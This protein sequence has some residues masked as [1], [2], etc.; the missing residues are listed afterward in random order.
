MEIFSYEKLSTQTKKYLNAISNSTKT[1]VFIFVLLL[2]GA[3]ISSRWFDTHSFLSR[4]GNSR[5]K[6]PWNTTQPNQKP[7]S[8]PNLKSNP[9]SSPFT[10]ICP[11]KNPS[12]TCS[13]RPSP[14]LNTSL[15]PASPP[16]PLASLKQTCPDY[17]RWIHE[18]LRPWASTGITREMLGRAA[19]HAAFRLIIVDGHP[20]IHIYHHVY[21]T[22]DIFTIWGILQLLRRYPGRVPDLDLMF[23]C[24]D[25][26]VVHA[27]N[28][29]SPP[30]LFRYCKD[31][32]TL[33]IVFPDWSFWGWPE[34]NIMPWERQAD[35]LREANER[36]PWRKR[37]P[38]AY[39]KGNPDVARTRG[40][41]MKCNV[42]TM[43]DWEAR[44]FRVNWAKEG[45]QKFKGANLAKQCTYRYKIYIEG[46]AW[47][48][49]EKYI[50][51]CD[52]PTLYVQS[53]FQDFVSRGLRP[54]LHYWPIPQDDK[55]RAIKQAVEWGNAH[56]LEMEAIG[57]EGS[58]FIHDQLHMNIVYDYMLHLLTEYSKLLTF[59][60]TK[61]EEAM[62]LCLESVACPFQGKIRDSLME[63][64]SMEATND[65]EPCSLPSAFGP[66]E[67]KE[68]LME[69]TSDG[70]KKVVESIIMKSNGGDRSDANYE[71]IK[72]F[73]LFGLYLVFNFFV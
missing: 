13:S 20:Y 35:E 16:T 9:N 68:L 39:W 45:R 4:M 62:D 64:M 52:S 37:E 6:F 63:S 3:F 70:T 73:L 18:D 50:I 26:P 51:G 60:P 58:S 29:Q 21:Q 12:N 27:I 59:K 11:T 30:P 42:T 32:T 14:F 19:P 10:L 47:S 44:L 49:S 46:N 15:S 53:R 2:M 54:G 38:Y 55:C 43:N 5:V 71:I 34:V 67:L 7:N 1:V 33:D 28:D 40:D 25:T 41:L 72:V 66:S 56:P 36:L 57:K 65:S 17:F 22:R 48:V 23:N 8:Q 61:P 69:K 31:D 24:E